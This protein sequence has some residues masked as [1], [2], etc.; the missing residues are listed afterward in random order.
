MIEDMALKIRHMLAHTNHT[1]GDI[2]HIKK[3]ERATCLYLSVKI[4]LKFCISVYSLT[5][6]L[7]TLLNF[8]EMDVVNSDSCY[9]CT[10]T[11]CADT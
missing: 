2:Q 3:G 1:V 5:P 9:N 10:I 11:A 8:I 6:L 7:C 4:S